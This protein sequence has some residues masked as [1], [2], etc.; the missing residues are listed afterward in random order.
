MLL[1]WAAEGGHAETAKLL[2]Q[3]VKEIDPV[4]SSNMTPLM[5]A[6]KGGHQETVKVL[7]ENKADKCA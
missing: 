1:H 7:L 3:Y 5:L 2:I 4:D 6:S